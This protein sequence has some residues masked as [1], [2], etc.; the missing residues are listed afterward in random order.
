MWEKRLLLTQYLIT[1]YLKNKRA[2]IQELWKRYLFLVN[3]N[4]VSG[5]KPAVVFYVID[6]VLQVAETFGKINL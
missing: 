5:L 1:G 4:P 2:L 6:A 3:G